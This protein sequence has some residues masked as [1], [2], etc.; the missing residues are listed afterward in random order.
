MLVKRCKSVNP[1]HTEWLFLS[2]RYF[3]ILRL[4]CHHW[5]NIFQ[6][7]Q[8]FHEVVDCILHYWIGSF[9]ICFSFFG[10]YLAVLFQGPCQMSQSPDWRNDSRFRT[11]AMWAH[12][13]RLLSVVTVKW[14]VNKLF[15]C[16]S[17]ILSF[18]RIS[19]LVSSW[20]CGTGLE[21]NLWPDTS[22]TVSN[23]WTFYNVLREILSS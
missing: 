1:R 18:M 9:L 21:E 15:W 10:L 6:R 22:T 17:V 11:F 7:L 2:F 19:F 14:T 5:N 13:F 20:N 3:V 16:S 8:M 12:L 4:V 23:P